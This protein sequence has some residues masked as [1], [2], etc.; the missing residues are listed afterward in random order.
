MIH[1]DPSPPSIAAIG[2]GPAEGVDPIIEVGLDH[3]GGTPVI[4]PI[5]Q[6]TS[7]PDMLRSLL[8]GNDIEHRV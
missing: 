7:A 6:I 4:N 8:T 1:L 5:L 3:Q 2:H